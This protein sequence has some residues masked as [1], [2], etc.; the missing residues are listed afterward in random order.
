MQQPSSRS[1]SRKQ[2]VL[3][4]RFLCNSSSSSKT[5]MLSVYPAHFI[6]ALHSNLWHL[7]EDICSCCQL[8]DP[9]ASK[10]LQSI[11]TI[12]WRCSLVDPTLQ[13][14]LNVC[15]RCDTCSL[16]EATPGHACCALL[17]CQHPMCKHTEKIGP[18]CWMYHCSINCRRT[19]SA[20][21]M[22]NANSSLAGVWL[23]GVNYM[24]RL[25]HPRS[26]LSQRIAIPEAY[27]VKGVPGHHQVVELSSWL[28]Q[29]LGVISW[30]VAL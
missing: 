23:M 30:G 26:I 9:E 12:S 28:L 16:V 22:M 4:R 5:K 8:R 19:I 20:S 10:S 2:Q 6:P 15:W 18:E 3:Y 1:R 29:N 11:L 13:A 7:L 25:C 27:W 14:I 17:P 24:H 21:H